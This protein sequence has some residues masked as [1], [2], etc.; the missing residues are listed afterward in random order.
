MAA[1]VLLVT[2]DG[3]G[4][5]VLAAAER[6]HGPL[7]LPVLAFDLPAGDG[8]DAALPAASGALRRIDS[9]DGVLVL[10][11]RAGGP[12]SRLA[13]ALAQLGTPVRRV[14]GLSLPMLLRV[15]NYAEQSLDE[16]A[17]TAAA[18]ARNGVV[19]DDA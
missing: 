2:H 1:G 9:G 4:A 18:G 19:L 7:P 15:L 16:L 11:D 5:A 8:H 6:V 13:A 10:V 14:S 17:L 3:L 12:S